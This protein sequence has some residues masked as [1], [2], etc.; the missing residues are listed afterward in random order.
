MFSRIMLR[1]KNK[2]NELELNPK[3]FAIFRMVDGV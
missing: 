1:Q 2:P 3:I